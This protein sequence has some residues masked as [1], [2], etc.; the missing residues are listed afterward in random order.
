MFLN[1]RRRKYESKKSMRV[2]LL[3]WKLLFSD[4]MLV[5]SD[6]KTD[7]KNI[8]LNWTNNHK[9]LLEETCVQSLLIYNCICDLCVC[10]HVF[11]INWNF[12]SNNEEQIWMKITISAHAYHMLSLC[13][14]L[15]NMIFHFNRSQYKATTISKHASIHVLAIIWMRTRS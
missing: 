7:S 9:S 14:Q 5:Y 1:K 11:S 3:V 10:D 4:N 15:C 12:E 6:E 13:Q 2:T 8:Y